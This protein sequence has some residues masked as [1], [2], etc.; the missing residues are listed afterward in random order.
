MTTYV[1]SVGPNS[2]FFHEL[3]REPRMVCGAYFVE[4]HRFRRTT[5]NLEEIPAER[6]PCL[7]CFDRWDREALEA[8]Q[9]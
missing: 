2:R 8:R 3:L 7:R 4:R 1:W 6:L 5:S 9:R